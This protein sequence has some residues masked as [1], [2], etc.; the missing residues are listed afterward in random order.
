MNIVIVTTSYPINEDGSE[1]A[2]SFVQD[3][4]RELEAQG[5]TVSVVYPSHE[6]STK[7]HNKITLYS[8]A[9]PHLPLSTLKPTKVKN[10]KA[11]LTTLRAG[12]NTVESAAIKSKADSILALWSLPSG[13]WARSAARKL[14]IQYSCWSLGSDIW[15]LGKI[16]IIKTVLKAV[17]KDSHHLF[18]DGEQ[19]CSDVEKLSGKPC[20]FLPSSRVLPTLSAQKKEKPPYRLC[21]LGRWHENKGTDLLV[22][23]LQQLTDDDWSR[24]E[25][26]T[27]AGG[28][29]L[30]D[31]IRASMQSL[32]NSGRSCNILGYQ[33]A[34]EASKLLH[35]SDIVVIPSRIES[36]PV[37]FSDAIQANCTVLATPV[38]DL[39]EL[40]K[41]FRC[42]LITESTEA[43]DIAEG[44]RNLTRS[45][46]TTYISGIGSAANYFSLERGAKI[47]ID[48]LNTL[49]QAG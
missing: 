7:K 26:F 5:H 44:I 21:F 29:P 48:S 32:I 39:P 49:E 23:A 28:G 20:D 25:S 10:W 9:V 45:D 18:A 13:Y 15:T 24:I 22:E 17:L 40:I 4:A 1:A 6:T 47:Y 2:G 41:R 16:P 43:A 36:I 30:N 27:L 8:F 38:G 35:H 34:R 31:T 11:I 42:G 12:H 14:D 37:I 19:L 33:N 46:I 3:F